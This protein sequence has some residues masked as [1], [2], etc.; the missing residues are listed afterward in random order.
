MAYT[1]KDRAE[2]AMSCRFCPMCHNV[3]LMTTLTRRE[4]YSPRGRGVIIHAVDKGKLK[5]DAGVAD[6]MYMFTTDGLSKH[7]CSGHLEHDEMVIDAR[8]SLVKAGAAPP[9]VGMLRSAIEKTGNPWGKKEPDLAK[10]TGAAAN[11]DLLVYF[12]PAARVQRPSAAEALGKLLNKAGVS[13]MVLKD[14]GDPG[15]MLYQLGENE[16]ANT[17]AAGLLKKIETSGAKKVVTADADAF[18]MLKS[19]FG[20]V[21]GG[22]KSVEVVHAADLLSELAGSG[23]LKFKKSGKKI[24]YHDP[25]ALARF[26]PCIDPPRAVVKAIEGTDPVEMP[27]NRDQAAC[28]GECGGLPFT[29][30]D[31]AKAAATRRRSQAADAGADLIVTASPLA[32]YHLAHGESGPEC[33]E[34]AEYAF[35]CLIS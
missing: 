29:N 11:A 5:W 18:R 2:T 35:D 25:C 34:L 3:D 20:E 4:T 16:A 30:V 26:A 1:D 33:K 8:R 15:V 27:W 10:L 32:A 22:P 19:G 23:K 31:V 14:E 12:G 24:T 6:V 28:S 17:A 21:A 7:M 13:F 9:P